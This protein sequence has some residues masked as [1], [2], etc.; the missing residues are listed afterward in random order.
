MKIK[1]NKIKIT[2]NEVYQNSIR[3]E[4]SLHLTKQ[5]LAYVPKKKEFKIIFKFVCIA[6]AEHSYSNKP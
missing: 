5:I 3:L 6:A 4:K 2:I 1:K